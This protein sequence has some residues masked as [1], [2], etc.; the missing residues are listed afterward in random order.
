AIAAKDEA[1]V[2][3]MR[4][5]VSA[6][7]ASVRAALEGISAPRYGSGELAANAKGLEIKFLRLK[8]DSEPPLEEWMAKHPSDA[9]KC[10]EFLSLVDEGRKKAGRLASPAKNGVADPAS[11]ALAGSLS[12]LEKRLEFVRD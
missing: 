2:A 11:K 1:M 3:E 10:E 9:P 6:R 7:H 8:E 4:M 5:K 12:R